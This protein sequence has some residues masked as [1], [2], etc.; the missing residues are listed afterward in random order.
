MD[1]RTTRTLLGVL[2]VVGLILSTYLTWSFLSGATP[3]C[4]VDTGVAGAQSSSCETVQGSPYSALFGIPLTAF[5]IVGYA[6]LLLSA[7]MAGRRGALTSL[8]MGVTGVAF[9]SY[10]MWVELFVIGLLCQLC[11]VC[12]AVMVISFGVAVVRF[13]VGPAKN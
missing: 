11:T 4:L 12:A 5:G 9:A 13:R 1:E 6:G 8:I 7:F 2:S 3:A 10:C